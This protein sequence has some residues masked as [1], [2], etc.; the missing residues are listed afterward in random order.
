MP[1]NEAVCATVEAETGPAGGGT[2]TVL[3]RCRRCNSLQSLGL[4]TIPKLKTF[5]FERTAKPVEGNRHDDCQLMQPSVE[6]R[7]STTSARKAGDWV[8]G[9]MGHVWGE[10]FRESRR[11]S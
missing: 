3:P 11:T 7:S 10:P 1:Q 8:I 9:R 5:G 4:F 2:R 6:R